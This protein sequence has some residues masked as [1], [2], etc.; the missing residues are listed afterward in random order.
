MIHPGSFVP[1]PVNQNDSLIWANVLF[2]FLQKTWVYHPSYYPGSCSWPGHMGP[3][4][5]A[6]EPRSLGPWAIDLLGSGPLGTARAHG[7]IGPWLPFSYFRTRLWHAKLLQ[8]EVADMNSDE[9]AHRLV[10][11]MQPYKERERERETERD[12]QNPTAGQYNCEQPTN[13]L[14]V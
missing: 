10:P 8:S 3:R 9:R 2:V 11:T 5:W 12:T 1:H 7:A 13:I 6:N 4:P 14:R